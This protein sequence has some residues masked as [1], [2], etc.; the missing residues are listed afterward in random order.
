[1]FN[2]RLGIFVRLS[3]RFVV[4]LWLS[5][6][7][8]IY[9]FSIISGFYCPSFAVHLAPFHWNIDF[10]GKFKNGGSGKQLPVTGRLLTEVSHFCLTLFHGGC[11][12]FSYA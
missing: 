11:I 1:M 4:F 2:R 6:R 12:G 3:C 8:A 5:C 7:F 9:F 10:L